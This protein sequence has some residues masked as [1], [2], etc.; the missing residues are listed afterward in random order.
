MKKT[1]LFLIACFFSV[2]LIKSQSIEDFFL[3]MPSEISPVISQLG[4]KE[5]MELYKAGKKAEVQGV[6]K[7]SC[8]MTAFQDNYI[9]I[10]TGSNSIEIISL[11][12]INDSYL[13]LVIKTV[14]APACDSELAFYTVQW[15]KLDAESLL[16]P[17]DKDWFILE[18]TDTNDQ[19]AKN[20]LLALDVSLMKFSYNPKTKQLIQEYQTPEYLDKDQKKKVKKYL[21]QEAK[22][23]QWTGTR[24]EK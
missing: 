3:S 20:A 18:G 10:A 12:M 8:S 13:L 16:H 5:L 6:L 1:L 9:R 7:E 4:R 21:K 22:T 14:C 2:T 15:K 24:F 23:Y 11:P 19:T 17:V